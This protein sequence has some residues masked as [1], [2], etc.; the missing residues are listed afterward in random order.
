MEEEILRC[1]VYI[2]GPNATV[3]NWGSFG[4]INIKMPKR[5]VSGDSTNFGEGCGMF[6][7]IFPNTL[8]LSQGL[9]K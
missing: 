3:R 6:K 7:F 5:H 8:H 4:F 1:K 2:Q 9:D